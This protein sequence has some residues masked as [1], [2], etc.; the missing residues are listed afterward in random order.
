MFGEG[1][2]GTVISNCPGLLSAGGGPAAGLHGAHWMAR[3]G[4]AGHSS[5]EHVDT[6]VWKFPSGPACLGSI[7]SQAGLGWAGLGAEEC[8]EGGCPEVTTPSTRYVRLP[9]QLLEEPSEGDGGC[10]SCTDGEVCLWGN[11]SVD[12]IFSEINCPVNSSHLGCSKA[13]SRARKQGCE[14]V[15]SGP[16]QQLLPL[17]GVQSAALFTQQDAAL[18]CTSGHFY[19]IM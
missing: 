18:K 3:D 12:G 4:W 14:W 8:K 11:V 7:G 17:A 15:S 2:A 6:P 5:K 13:E 16:F 1:A 10:G 9:P 19:K